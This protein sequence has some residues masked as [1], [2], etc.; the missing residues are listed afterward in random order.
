MA[1]SLSQS[2]EP[3]VDDPS[4]SVL[5]CS[6]MYQEFLKIEE[7]CE[8][9]IQSIISNFDALIS[10]LRNPDD[11]EN[12]DNNSHLKYLNNLELL[13]SMT[14]RHS[15]PF[16]YK[17]LLHLGKKSAFINRLNKYYRN[18]EN[19]I[20]SKSNTKTLIIGCGPAGLRMAIELSLFGNKD[21]ELIDSRDNWSRKQIVAIWNITESDL[22][23]FGIRDL[24]PKFTKNPHKKSIPITFLQHFLLRIA[25]I[26]GIKIRTNLQFKGIN[27]KKNKINL[28][29]KTMDKL[30]EIDNNYDILLDATGTVAAL[31]DC[32]YDDVKNADNDN[33]EKS[34]EIRNRSR[35]RTRSRSSVDGTGGIIGSRGGSIHLKKDIFG[36]VANFKR[37]RG[38]YK[39]EQILG[40]SY[41]FYQ[42]EF[43][44]KQIKLENI[45]Y[46]RSDLTNYLVAT[47]KKESL[48]GNDVFIDNKL[49]GKKLLKRENINRDKLREMILTVANEWKIPHSIKK[50]P[51]N[52]LS[53]N[54]EDF[55]VF[56]FG[57]LKIA[58]QPIKFIK[59]RKMVMESQENQEDE[60]K[61]V[62]DKWQMIGC[63]GDAECA[64]FW[65]K[66]TGVNHAWIGM[67]LMVDIIKKWRMKVDEE[68]DMEDEEEWLVEVELNAK[69]DF[70]K[71]HSDLGDKIWHKKKI[72]DK[73]LPD[74]KAHIPLY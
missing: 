49:K 15:I 3:K 12:D 65:P 26:L 62:E 14:T 20:L 33:D 64:P 43:D 63:L 54:K 34:V 56:E 21:I 44:S 27:F 41:H 30:Q 1:Q 22:I 6:E 7:H 73:Y 29:N 31:R 50:N 18:N 45:V 23:S 70:D 9:S 35:T 58:K 51:F 13:R 19:D 66:G 57:K 61:E 5:S 74:Y 40:K 8:D 52:I 32:P 4:P 39:T 17:K 46:Y 69:K 28:Y 25:L 72:G 53:N 36:I 59:Q 42:K 68:E 16:K 10:K 24:I 48:N 38:D 11:L 37:V 2:E 55:A 71:L 47:V 67:Y 60:E